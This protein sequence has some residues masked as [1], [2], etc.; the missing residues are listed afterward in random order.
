MILEFLTMM[1]KSPYVSS[2][3]YDENGCCMSCGY[4]WCET[5]QE[6]IRIWETYCESLE[7]G[8]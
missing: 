4:S 5:L 2:S 6:C 1:I 8:H 7:N 3:A